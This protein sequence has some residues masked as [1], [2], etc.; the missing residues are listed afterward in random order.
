M[1]RATAFMVAFLTL[2]RL[3]AQEKLPDYAAW[4]TACAKLPANRTLRGK[5][6]DNA[7]LPLRTFAEFDQ[8]LEGFHVEER[9]GPLA[10]ADAWVGKPPDAKV[11]FDATRSWYGDADVPF[12][13]FA[14]KLVLPSDAV[15]VVLGDLH[16]DIRSLLRVLDELNRKKIL[17]GFKLRDAKH[18]LIFLGDYTDRGHYGTEVLYTLLRLKAAN[19]RQVHLV[20]IGSVRRPR[21]AQEASRRNQ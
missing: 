13:P 8:A 20:R 2:S 11:F 9:R 15:A 5:P 16:G 19:A 10:K 12:Q 3:A 21:A 18:H 14:E 1:I 4:A 6:P 7:V 17:D